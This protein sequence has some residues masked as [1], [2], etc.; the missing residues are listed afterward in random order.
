MGD[1]KDKLGKRLKEEEEGRKNEKFRNA[2][3]QIEKKMKGED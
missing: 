2:T 1:V 3:N